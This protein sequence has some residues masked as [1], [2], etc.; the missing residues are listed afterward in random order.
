MEIQTIQLTSKKWKAIQL[1]GAIGACI[2][3]IFIGSAVDFISI[4]DITIMNKFLL[5]SGS[6]LVISGLTVFIVG[7]IGGW[8]NHG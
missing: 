5:T 2:G 8:W 3:S 6:F 7:R 4:N 1:I